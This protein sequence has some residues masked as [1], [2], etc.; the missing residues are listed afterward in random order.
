MLSVPGSSEVCDPKTPLTYSGISVY[1]MSGDATFNLAAWEG[2]GGAE[3]RLSAVDGL[4]VSD[5]SD[6]AVC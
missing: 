6:G 1:R 5:Q 2:V 4:L 3:Y